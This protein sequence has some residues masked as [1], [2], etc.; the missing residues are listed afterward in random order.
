MT[1][2]RERRGRILVVGSSNTDLVC[3]T[4]RL[5]RAGETV[6]SVAFNVYP[7]GK[8]ANQAVAAARAGA[9]TAFVG[10]FGDDDYG[11][12]RRA[13][14]DAEGI[15][16]AHAITAEGEPSGLA[17]IAVDRAG[18][19]LIVTVAGANGRVTVNQFDAALAS[20]SVDVILLPNEAPPPVVTRAVTS[21]ADATV[22]LNAAPFEDYLRDI[23]P[24]VDV[25]ICNT[26]EA[27][28]FIGRAVDASSAGEAVRDLAGM[29][30][31]CAVITL[32][33]AGAVGWSDGQL[34]RVPA[35]EVDAVDTTGAG[36]AFCGA[37]AAWL[38]E[39]ASFE[40]AIK[41]G[42]VAGSLAATRPGAQPSLPE[43]DEIVAY[44]ER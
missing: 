15:D 18:E 29:S 25:L 28:Q 9:Q 14:L 24:D 43:R 19:N 31:G 12:A 13:E 20:D 17:L 6:A 38:G 26:V 7:G 1:S 10:G 5:P 21:G 2:G 4:D 41:A 22:V 44:L 27:G 30:R 32:G 23:V 33:A 42:T 37:F 35:M 3:Q 34:W 16:L 8:A 39:G 36:D 40:D 11:A